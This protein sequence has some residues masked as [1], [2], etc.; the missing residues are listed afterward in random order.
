MKEINH[1]DDRRLLAELCKHL[2]IS[3]KNLKRDELDYSRLVGRK[4]YID[5]DS[6]YWYVRVSCRSSI[7]WKR[8]KNSL[9][10]MDLWQDGEDEGALRLLRHPSEEEAQKIRQNIGFTVSRKLDEDAKEK[11]VER[12]LG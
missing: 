11:L 4:G 6:T 7:L 2:F 10:F 8:V 5:S 12:L 9:S 1:S 3:K